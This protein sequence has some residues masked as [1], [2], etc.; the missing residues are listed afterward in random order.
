MGRIEVDPA[1][2]SGLS[3][4]LKQ[5][6]A[7]G[8]DAHGRLGGVGSAQTGH[9]GLADAVGHF[10]KEWE[11]SLKKIGENAAA[12]ADKLGKSADG[13]RTTDQG[14]ADAATGS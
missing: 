7:A 11:Y 14:I 6:S 5:F 12:M 9:N 2:L 8:N 1:E 10:V 4:S 3:G 13:Y